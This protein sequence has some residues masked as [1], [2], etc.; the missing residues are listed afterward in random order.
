MTDTLKISLRQTL[1][2]V[3]S[4]FVRISQVM[5]GYESASRRLF[6]MVSPPVMALT[7]YR[8]S[9]WLHT[10]GLTF[11]AWPLY[12]LNYYLTNADIPPATRIGHSCFL[13]HAAGTVLCGRIGS[14]AMIF[15]G[16]AVGGGTG[17]VRDI[18]GGPGLPVIEDNVILGLR[19]VVLGPVHVGAGAT[20]GATAFV[21]RDIE[22]GDTVLPPQP[23]VVNTQGARID[24]DKLAG[25]K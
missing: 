10:R 16:A 21:R 5:G 13:G 25:L 23:T 7:L 18:G 9:H 17:D 12:L 4:D 1:G 8:L 14:N 22:P 3:R 6:W 15:G 20:V 11:L 24:Y 2:M 19:C